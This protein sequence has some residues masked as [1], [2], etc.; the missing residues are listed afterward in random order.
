[1][2]QWFPSP[3]TV[4]GTTYQNAEMWMM[5]H[6]A[7]LFGDVE[8]AEQMKGVKDGDPK[9]MQA[10]GRRAKGFDRGVWDERKSLF[11]IPFR[12]GVRGIC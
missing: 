10:L 6:K 12:G 7:L 11:L 3:F 2:S 9:E 8:I 4:S 1:M 5:V